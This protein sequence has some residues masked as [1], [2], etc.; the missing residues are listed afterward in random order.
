MSTDARLRYAP[1][2]AL[3]ICIMA[4]GIALMLDKLHILEA[5]RILRFWPVGLVLLGAGVVAQSLWPGTEEPAADGK[6]RPSATP[7]LVLVVIVT[8]FLIGPRF[9][10]SNLVRSDARDTVSLFAVMGEDQRTSY[11]TTFRGGEM[12]SFMGSNKLDLR[13]AT[14]APGEEAVIDVFAMMGGLE[15]R[16]PDGWTVVVEAV[17]VMGGVKD[18]R[19]HAGDRRALEAERAPADAGA[20]DIKAPEANPSTAPRVVVRGFIIMGGLVIKS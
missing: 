12:T 19:L 13:Q 14:L 18:Q 16:V 9:G 8:G 6:R 11:A 1:N 20:S 17:P 15:L 2:L 10:R 7:L 5:E 3:G 4:I